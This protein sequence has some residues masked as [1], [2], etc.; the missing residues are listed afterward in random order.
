[1]RWFDSFHSCVIVLVCNE[2][3]EI[4]LSKQWY[5]PDHFLSIT[6]GYMIPGEN[7]EEAAKREVREELGLELENIIYAGTYWLE[8]VEQLLHGFIGYTHKKE[9]KLS[10]EI[11]FAEWVPALEAE[12][13]MFRD[14]PGGGLYEVYHKFLKIRGFES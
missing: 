5:L 1:K 14:K 12:K 2:F 4:A 10:E 7:A 8:P 9:L 11:P 13:K 6:S 3:D